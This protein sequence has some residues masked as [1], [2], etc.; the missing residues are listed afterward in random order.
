[1]EKKTDDDVGLSLLLFICS[2][3]IGRIQLIPRV[4]TI[5][6]KRPCTYM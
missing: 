3:F 4:W 2:W 6:W 1:M 5:S